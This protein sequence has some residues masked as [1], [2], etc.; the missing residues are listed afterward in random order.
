MGMFP[1]MSEDMFP[2]S[3]EQDTQKWIRKMLCCM[4]SMTKEGIWDLL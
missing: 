1:G 2:K 4:D 3:S